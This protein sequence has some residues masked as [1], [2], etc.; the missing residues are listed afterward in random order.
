TGMSYAPSF[1]TRQA[2]QTFKTSTVAA[3]SKRSREVIS[4]APGDRVV[5][6]SF[7]MGT[8][9]TVD[10]AGEKSVASV[11]FGSGGVK[12]LLLRYAPVQKL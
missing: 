5:H 7:G 3:R 10:G 12:R 8:V 6:D 9:V 1:T 11:D 2:P 4:L